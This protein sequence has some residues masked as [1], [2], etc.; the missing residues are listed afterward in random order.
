M[1]ALRFDL[2]GLE[3]SKHE[4]PLYA[5]SIVGALLLHVGIA[6]SASHAKPGAPGKVSV[7]MLIE[8]EAVHLPERVAPP[9]PPPPAAPEPPQ[10]TER[11]PR[12][13]AAASNAAPVA[14]TDEPAGDPDVDPNLEEAAPLLTDPMGDADW[15][16][17]SGNGSALSGG[18]S[19]AG[20]KGGALRAAYLAPRDFSREPIGPDLRPLVKRNY[21]SAAKMY[22]YEATV[23]I[24]FVVRADGSVSDVAVEDVDVDGRGFGE[25]CTRTVLQGGAWKPRLDRNGRPV[26]ATQELTCS[27]RLPKPAPGTASSATTPPG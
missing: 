3:G 11:A 25:A 27:F 17:A 1:Q 6:W 22:G 10:A 23:R 5:L 24:S 2:S 13:V 20:G 12:A 16:L 4:R 19:K 18:V 15:S 9:P 26:E 21:P 7:P 14:P 8:V